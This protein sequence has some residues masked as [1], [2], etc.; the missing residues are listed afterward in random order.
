MSDVPSPVL[1][2]GDKYLCQKNVN[3]AK[4][5]YIDFKWIVLS[6]T[7]SS[8]DKIRLESGTRDIFARKKL[9]LIKEIPNHKDAREFL[10]DLVKSSSDSLKFILW[11]SENVIKPD[12]KTKA[13]N[14][15]WSEFINELKKNANH[16]IINN[17]FEFTD[18]EEVLGIDFV[19]AK[20]LHRGKNID[21]EA[22]KLFIAIVGKSRGVIETEVEK[23]CITA[24][25]EVKS[26]FVIENTYPSS[27]EAVLFKFGNVLDTTYSKSVIMMQEFLDLGINPNVLAEIMAKKARW[28]LVVSHLWSEGMSWDDIAKKIITMGKFPSYIW[29]DYQLTPTQKRKMTENNKLLQD[30]IDVMVKSGGL[31]DIFFDSKKKEGKAEAIPWDFIAQQYVN[32]VKE[33]IVK[34][35]I[36]KYNKSET[37]QKVLNRALKVYLFVVKKLKEIRYGETPNQD[38]QEMVAALTSRMI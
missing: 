32:F 10:L 17:G 18:K 37:H 12:P 19:K 23:L 34:P 7:E 22:A 14:K 13:F 26:N 8:F 3:S 25:Q 1:M 15:T 4:K 6:A 27:D 31:P 2:I 21:T 30:R 35:N 11:D 20:F 28:Q 16:K 9:L 29:H 36:N 24:P 38:L 5:K 33:G